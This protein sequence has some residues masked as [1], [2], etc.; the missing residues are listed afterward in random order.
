MTKIIRMTMVV[1]LLVAGVV[2]TPARIVQADPNTPPPTMYATPNTTT[3]YPE[4]RLQAPATPNSR[5]AT[6]ASAITDTTIL[7]SAPTIDMKVLVI[8][9]NGYED[10]T[11]NTEHPYNMVKSYLDI[12]GIPYD[13]VDLDASETVTEAMLWDGVNHGYYYAI[14][15]TTS[16]DWWALPLATREIIAAYERNFGVRQVTWYSTPALTQS[17]MVCALV[18]PTCSA[19]GAGI[20]GPIDIRMTD[21]GQEIF[22]YLQ[23]DAELEMLAISEYTYGYPATTT[24][25]T[26]A[27]VTPLFLD[28]NGNIAMAIFRPGDG[29]EHLVFTWSSYYPATPPTNIHARVLPYGVINWATKGVFLGERHVYFVP[30]PDD[31]FSGGDRWDTV[32]KVIIEDPPQYRLIPSDLDNLV[33]W[34]ANFRAT[35][36]NAADFKMEMPFNGA[37]TLQDRVGG[38]Q[39]GAVNPGTL[40][41]KAVQLQSQFIWLNHT[42]AHLDLDGASYNVAR[43]EI[44][45][46]HNEAASLGLTDY[47][48]RTLL[49]GD[50]QGLTTTDVI[51]AAYDL[52]VRYILANASVVPTYTNPSPNTGIPHSLNSEILLVPRHA[53]NIFYFSVTPEEETDYYN[54]AYCPGYKES[55][56]T[57][58]RCFD[59]ATVINLITNQSL[60]NLLNFN[61]NATMFHMNNIIAY[62]WPTQT[63]TILSDFVESL[64]GKY[65]TYYS[66]VPILSLRTQ[67]IGEKMWERMAY[68]ASGVA[69]VWTCGNAIT[70]T[71]S[72]AARIPITGINSGL[73]DYTETYAG[74]DISYFDLNANDTVFIEGAAASIPAQISGLSVVVGNTQNVLTWNA[75]TLDTNGAAVQ[76]LFYRVYRNGALIANRVATTTYTDTSPVAGVTYTVTAIGNNC[77]KRESAGA[78][79]TPTAPLAVSTSTLTT[80][81]SITWTTSVETNTLGFNLYRAAASNGP[82]TTKVNTTLIP[83][84]GSGAYTVA[85]SGA[86]GE[87][88]YYRLE[89]VETA[90]TG[91][92]TLWYAPFFVDIGVAAIPYRITG[93]TV[94]V[95][96]GQNALSWNPTVSDTTGAPLGALI[97]RVYR[98][99]D[100]EFTP[101]SGTLLTETTAASY[102]DASP[103]DG[104]TY[105][106]T[107]IGNNAWRRES[108]PTRATPTAILEFSATVLAG[109]VTITWTTQVET[110]TLGFNLYISTPSKS[111]WTKVNAETILSKGGGG[112]VFTDP[113]DRRGGTF[114]YRIEEVKDAGTGGATLWYTPTSVAIGPNAVALVGVEAQASFGALFAPL[115][116]VI[117]VIGNKVRTKKRR[118]A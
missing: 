114:S 110:H 28:V 46:N 116:V 18:D 113:N 85:D 99:P 111:A 118:I 96:S 9:G 72:G 112:Y 8:Y 115:G 26:N 6:M 106:V 31:I 32:N 79:A 82:W 78:S 29:R 24:V 10:G 59:Y 67:E 2:T 21:A 103:V 48:S 80:T 15:F 56:G 45:N 81:V 39:S 98:S 105:A 33:T 71:T 101:S 83:A 95:A 66:N 23:P 92:A 97:Y 3:A 63:N 19:P 104:A 38:V 54:W 68:D 14:F 86:E 84:Q 100:A 44:L 50:Y 12:L 42:Y 52:G 30:Q 64:Y 5:F 1:M 62:N 47:T 69:A 49:T 17:G 13:T 77:W 40:T 91:G 102:T 25:A 87:R 55:G 35:M 75:T 76:A 74:Q 22:H 7:I 73:A 58:P 53:N 11:L 20:P 90:A 36:T 107:A 117:L 51:N 43:N 88:I 27:Q 34:M 70:L 61:V 89:E 60:E 108:A 16:D 37:G 65:N 109:T 4:M 93:L 94:D 41:A 57:I